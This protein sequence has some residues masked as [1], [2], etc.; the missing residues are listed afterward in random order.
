MTPEDLARIHA[1]AFTMPR[2]WS[3]KEFTDLLSSPHVFLAPT[4]HAFAMGRVIADEA[5]LLTIATDPGHRRTGLGRSCLSAFEAAAH[6]RGATSAFLEVAANNPAALALYLGNDWHITG[7]RPQ[8]YQAPDGT[9]VDAQ[10]LSKHL[11]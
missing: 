6:A 8:Y 5:E 3:V 1:A 9:R 7:T 10:I 2:P 4:Q 11:A